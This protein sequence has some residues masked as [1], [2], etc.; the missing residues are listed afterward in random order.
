MKKRSKAPRTKASRNM[1]EKYDFSKGVRG[2]YAARFAEGTNVV[3]IDPDVAVSNS[4]A[5][6]TWR[7]AR[8]FLLAPHPG[9]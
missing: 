6:A 8:R 1:R 3:V 4:F 2:K 9:P 5:S 7:H